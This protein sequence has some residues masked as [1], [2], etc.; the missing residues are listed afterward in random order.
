MQA[1]DTFW[2]RQILSA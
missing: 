2:S 1:L